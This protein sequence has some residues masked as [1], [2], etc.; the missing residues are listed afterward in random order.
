MLR[1][2]VAVDETVTD[3]RHSWAAQAIDALLAAKALV[4][5]ARSTGTRVDPEHLARHVHLLRC[6][7]LLGRSATAHRGDA[8]TKKHNALASRIIARF[9]DHVRFTTDPAVPFDDNPAEREIL[10][11]TAKRAATTLHP[12]T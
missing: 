5:T 10:L 3:G 4:D 12:S 2:P 9:D 8:I 6:A 1:E 7:A 11:G